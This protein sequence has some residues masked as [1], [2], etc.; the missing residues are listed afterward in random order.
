MKVDLSSQSD[1]ALARLQLHHNDWYVRT[2]R[3]LLQERAA[4]GRDMAAAH[5]VLREILSTNPDV[6]R[7]LRAIW[8]LYATGGLDE[9]A[10]RA[11]LDHPS[12]HVR[13]WAIRLLVDTGPPA[14]ATV[15][16]FAELAK[17]DPSQKVRLS[18]ASALQRLPI[19]QCWDVA[20]PLA[21]HAE[22]AADRVLPLMIWYGVERLVPADLPRAVGW[23]ARCKIP[24]VRQYVARRAVTADP[25]TGLAAC[26]LAAQNHG[27][28]DSVCDDLLIT[29]ATRRCEV[30]NTSLRPEGWAAAFARL[31]ARP[32]PVLIE[33]TLMLALDFEEPKAIAILRG[34]VK[35]PDYAPRRPA[36]RLVGSGR[37]PRARNRPRSPGFAR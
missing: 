27:L 18:L 4:S 24:L 22:D 1:E 37:A 31:V 25:S 13:A 36:S 19:N 12:E 5:R 33:Q 35:N 30:V 15:T 11:L 10:G 16:R 21:S 6:T 28:E 2:S 23:V 7:Q 3:R 8:A 14:A 17:T 29:G 9:N 32:N 20:E 34:M 26:R